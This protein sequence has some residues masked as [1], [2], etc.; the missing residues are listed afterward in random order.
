MKKIYL[1]LGCSLLLQ[2]SNNLSAQ[3][4]VSEDFSSATG[5]TPPVN[6]TNNDIQGDGNIWEF[7]NPGG[8]DLNLPISDPAAIFDSDN[9]GNDG[10]AEDCALESPLFDASATTNPIFLS[11]DQYFDSDYG[12]MIAVEVWDG[13]AWVEV[14]SSF[15][16]SPDP[17]H[18]LIDITADLNGASDAQ[19]R[20][21]WMG[22]YSMYWIVDNIL[23]EAV[24]CIPVSDLAIDNQGTDFM[25]LSWTI[26]GTETAWDIEY[27]V[28]GFV[29][30]TG[31]ELGTASATSNPTTLN[32]LDPGMQY[33][34]YVRANCGSDESYWTLV[35]GAT[36]CAPVTNFPWMDDVESMG[37]TG[38]G[39]VPYCWLNE[40]GEWF[41]D[42]GS[43]TGMPANSGTNFVGI[44]YGSNDHLWTPEFQMTAGTTYEFSFMWAGDGYSGWNGSVTVN[45]SQS[46]TGETV[47]GVPFIAAADNTD[48][49]F[50][51]EFFCFTP[52]T[53]GTYS[54]AIK[55]SASFFPYILRFDDFSVVERAATAGTNGTLDACQINGLVDLENIVTVNDQQGTWNFSPNP[56]TIVN[57]NQFNPQFVPAGTVSV[58]YV[59]YGCLVDTASALITIYPPS[60]AG[61]DGIITACKSEPINLLSGL[62][63]T[64]NFGGDWYDPIN[65]QLPS[66]NI[67]TGNFPGQF[68]Y[69][70]ITGNGVCP[71]DTASVVVTVT[72]CNWLSVDEAALEAMNLYPNPSTGLV[73]IESSFSGGTFNLEITDING[74]VVEH[75]G[76]T[77]SAGTSTVNLSHVQ[78]GT[79]FFRM[80]ND[81]AEKVYRVVIQ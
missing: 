68:N 67:I 21:H 48:E 26:N 20:F 8:R 50:K 5:N 28:P 73:Y 66:G 57:G 63:G 56:S 80:S 47:L 60:S 55:V 52:T 31:T 15:S 81:Q 45:N 58:D 30:G 39:I 72:S 38:D 18:I 36:D 42:D 25:D 19:V 9:Y 35:S 61:V 78:K 74:R 14:Y 6:W 70:Y 46:S 69:K 16:T 23:V 77:I 65:T 22:D 37:Q 59:T 4:L 44:Y 49:D 71:D 3:V 2:W 32:G 51:R 12:G 7:D 29:P 17:E 24:S 75:A 27:G 62:G 13:S 11:F 41:S 1:L 43:Y 53:S 64:V 33:D 76:N 79:Y 40:N 54:F 10:F 34:V